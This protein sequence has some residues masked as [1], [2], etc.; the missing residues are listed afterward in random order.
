MLFVCLFLIILGVRFA[1]NLILGSKSISPTPTLFPTQ[2]PALTPTVTEIFCGGIAGISCPEG[3]TCKLDGNY[4]DAGGKCIKVNLSEQKT[5]CKSPRPQACTEECLLPPPYLCGSNGKSYCT[6]CQACADK[7]VEWYQFQDEPC[8]DT[9]SGPRPMGDAASKKECL[10]KGGKWQQW[11]LIPQEYCQIPSQDA[12][13]PCTDGSQCEY[14]LCMSREQRTPG[15]CATYRNVFG[16]YSIVR[17]G[18]TGS[19]LC[20]D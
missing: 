1:G 20:V 4:P 5:Y 15:V 12:G 16:C 19:G 8:T 6:K 2:P 11:G 7:K 3:F 17:N 18:Q 9:G 14:E 13:K 10:E